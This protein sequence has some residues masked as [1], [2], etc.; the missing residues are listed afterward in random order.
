MT[1]SASTQKTVAVVGDEAFT[2][3]FHLAGVKK[4]RVTTNAN[5]FAAA[6]TQ[7]LDDRS[8]GIVVTRATDVAGLPP[9][10]KTRVTESVDPVVI[11]M[12]AGASGGLRDKI[13]NAIGIDLLQE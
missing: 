1:T 11:Q 8:V 7:L 2:L 4:A 3:G 5:E 6:L 12:G 10:L 13:R 9:L